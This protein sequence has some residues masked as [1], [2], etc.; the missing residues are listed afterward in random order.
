MLD[1]S[2]VGFSDRRET[3]CQLMLIA[4]DAADSTVSG[5]LNARD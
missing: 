3:S 2:S 5:H 4:I 1:H